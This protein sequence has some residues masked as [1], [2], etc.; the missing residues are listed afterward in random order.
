MAPRSLTHTE[1]CPEVV[2]GP[3]FAPLDRV[4]L[5]HQGAV[6]CTAIKCDQMAP[7]QRVPVQQALKLR[8]GAVTEGTALRAHPEQDRKILREA[9]GFMPDAG[10]QS[11]EEGAQWRLPAEGSNLRGRACGFARP[12]PLS[13]WHSTG[14]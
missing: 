8:P 5:M 12:G 4:S 2:M 6:L 3:M 1:P 14:H 10:E 9:T 13:S 7:A 11:E